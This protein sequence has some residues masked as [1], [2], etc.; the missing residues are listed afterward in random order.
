MSIAME[1]RFYA[2]LSANPSRR[3]KSLTHSRSRKIQTMLGYYPKMGRR[4]DTTRDS[5]RQNL[6]VFINFNHRT[7][8]AILLREIT[9]MKTRNCCYQSSAPES[10]TTL[11]LLL[12]FSRSSTLSVTLSNYQHLVSILDKISRQPITADA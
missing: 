6:D 7:I 8:Y 9:T 3:E 4:T 1:A 11:A 5:R 12:T 2:S 10:P